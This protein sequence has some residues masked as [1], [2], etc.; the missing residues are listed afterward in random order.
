MV[1]IARSW[2]IIKE[3]KINETSVNS[4]FLRVRLLNHCIKMYPLKEYDIIKISP[5]LI[6]TGH[7]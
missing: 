7:M 5:A 2:A 3:I 1:Y 4:F 6:H